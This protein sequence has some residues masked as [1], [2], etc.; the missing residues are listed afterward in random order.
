MKKSLALATQTTTQIQFEGTDS[1]SHDDE[2]VVVCLDSNGFVFSI[3]EEQ[4]VDSYNDL[5]NCTA[6]L[7]RE[8]AE[9]LLSW[10]QSALTKEPTS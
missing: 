6:R 5:L 7:N 4:A 9:K 2:M 3:A 1:W 10:L 8:E